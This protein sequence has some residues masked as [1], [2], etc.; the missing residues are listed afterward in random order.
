[1][2]DW[3]EEQL[4]RFGVPGVAVT[5]VVGDDVV[6]SDGFGVR[7]LPSGEPVTPSTSFALASV[8]KA[9]TAAAVGALVDDGVL[10]WDEPVRNHIPGFTLFD[11]VA[12]ERLCLRDML[13]HR[14]GLPRHD[15]LWY[16]NDDLD[17]AGA[18]ER[19]RH[20][21]PNKDF[22]T[23]WQYNNNMFLAAGYLCGLVTGSTW[24][25]V[26]RER[27]FEPLGMKSSAFSHEEA[28]IH[29]DVSTGHDMRQDEVTAIPYSSGSHLCGPAG[30]IYST[31][32]D[33]SAW[34]RVNLGGGVLDG[35]R[36]LSEDTVREMQRPQMVVPEASMFP[37]VR[38]IGYGLGWQIGNYRGHKM[39][40]HGGNIDGFT[41]LVTM[42]PEQRI[43]MVLLC[44]R[45]ATTLRTAAAYHV[46]DEALG[47]EANPWEDRFFELQ[48]SMR[49]GGLEAKARVHRV[50]G[51]PPSHSL[52]DYA[53]EYEHPAYGTMSIAVAETDDRLEPTWR[54][55]EATIAHR[56][57]DVFD[58]DIEGQEAAQMPLTFLTNA[59]G[60]ISSLTMPL[61]PS[62]E[63]IVF[64]RLP[65]A[66]LTDPAALDAFVGRYVMGPIELAVTQERPGTL[67]MKVAIPGSAPMELE[68]DRGTRF[69]VKGSASTTVT[70][71][72]TDAGTVAE[73]LV[74]PVGVFLPVS[75]ALVR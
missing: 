7:D 48:E 29:T 37:E 2:K 1:M 64:R 69:R 39:V 25:D 54:A 40:H 32:D 55:L 47:L 18:V 60:D 46:F 8:T 49:T 57:Y 22:R 5:V 65:D 31:L 33:M 14:S 23:T 6:V 68:A 51:A 75:P 66:R 43:G 61:E 62:V 71:K 28:A 72:L 17:R 24:E 42:L 59:E 26:V 34:L 12:T 11:P 30:S 63:P 38:E 19:L 44:N 74:Q 3:I 41:T 73:A 4:D 67:K 21:K 58:V 70:F 45:N 20:L 56:H 16:A 50:D 10:D 13:S 27:V 15:M 9:F 52:A 36:V 53:G 35:K